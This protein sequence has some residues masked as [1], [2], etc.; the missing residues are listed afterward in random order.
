MRSNSVTVD[1]S[2]AVYFG[3]SEYGIYKFWMVW[4]T[5]ISNIPP[6][7]PFVV[8]DS[9]EYN[10]CSTTSILENDL[11]SASTVHLYPNPTNDFV[12]ISLE[13]EE[14]IKL[15]KIYNSTGKLTNVLEQNSGTLDFSTLSVGI[16][17]VEIQ[18]ELSTYSKKVIKVE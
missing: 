9:F 4:D 1:T 7:I 6:P 17:Y 16:Y 5:L 13:N 3:N 2:Y 11:N 14:R 15:I 12:N 8:L 10:P 18:T